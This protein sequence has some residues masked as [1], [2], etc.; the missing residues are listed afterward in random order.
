MLPEPK[1]DGYGG[2][3]DARKLKLGIPDEQYPDV[4]R[5]VEKWDF[6]MAA[7]FQDGQKD[8]WKTVELSEVDYVLRPKSQE[9]FADIREAT[10]GRFN[11][12]WQQWLDLLESDP[13][14]YVQ[15]L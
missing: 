10:V 11:P 1:P 2:M 7:G 3:I 6:L 13:A 15:I 8:G 4:Y 12:L 5:L 14:L 9:V